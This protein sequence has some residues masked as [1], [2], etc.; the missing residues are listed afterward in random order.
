[1]PNGTAAPLPVQKP[2]TTL[3]DLLSVVQGPDFPTGGLILGRSGIMDYF[4]RGRG[5]L[6]SAVPA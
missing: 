3:A 1:M 5:S 4:V 2:S 6:K